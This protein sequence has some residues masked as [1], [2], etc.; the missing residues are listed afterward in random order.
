MKKFFFLFFLVCVLAIISFNNCKH[1][2]CSKIK[3]DFYTIYYQS[4]LFKI[5]EI[6]NC[7]IQS[8]K[9]IDKNS[10][11]II[12]HHYGNKKNH[13]TFY[14]KNIDIR[15]LKLIEKNQKN[16]DLVILNGDIFKIPSKKKWLKLINFFEDLNLNF[17]IAPGNH[18]THINK[19]LDQKI[20][21]DL[22]KY[23]YPI[24]LILEN[25]II[26][27]RDTIN[28]GWSLK[29][30]EIKLINSFPS[31]KEIFIIQHHNALKE[32]RYLTNARKELQSKQ[33]ISEIKEFHQGI[34]KNFQINFIIGDSGMRVNQKRVYCKMFKNIK[35][36]INGLGGFEKDK[37]LV[38]TNDELFYLNL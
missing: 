12:G 29:E 31:K 4:F 22:F 11:L 19:N 33:G 24:K 2:R 30:N 16:I 34:N 15:L 21:D 37:I 6:K 20:F 25:K 5:Y 9:K 7:Q 32:F 27:I 8:T 38:M 23:K 28:M 36:V 35:Y 1:W 3:S 26:Y 14:D 10:T 18:D 13:Y 17:I